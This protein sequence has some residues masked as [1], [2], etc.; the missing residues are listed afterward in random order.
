[1]CGILLF[2]IKDENQIKVRMITFSIPFFREWM[3]GRGG[4]GGHE[5]WL[6]VLK[7]VLH[8]NFTFTK[9]VHISWKCRISCTI[10]LNG[11]FNEKLS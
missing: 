10:F 1:M 11:K 3:K 4:G 8:R 7:V 2:I 6:L 9:T 5:M